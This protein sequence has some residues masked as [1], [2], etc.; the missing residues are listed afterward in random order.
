MNSHILRMDSGRHGKP[1]VPYYRA[2]PWASSRAAA[3][4][5][6]PGTV[7]GR[8]HLLFQVL[9]V[10]T[11]S[12]GRFYMPARSSGFCDRILR[13]TNT[14]DRNKKP[15][16]ADYYIEFISQRQRFPGQ[17]LERW[18]LSSQDFPACRDLKGSACPCPSIWTRESRT[19]QDL[20]D[21]IPSS[22]QRSGRWR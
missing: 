22:C 10:H 21:N 15:D 6:G 17:W 14:P 20:R 12:D 4:C 1:P 5:R 3:P 2:C 11:V 16:H 19:F 13:R 9:P 8:K 7:Y 18:D